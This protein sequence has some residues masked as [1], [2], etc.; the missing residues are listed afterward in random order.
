M[1]PQKTIEHTL[2]V[3]STLVGSDPWEDLIASF[4]RTVKVGE[5]EPVFLT[6]PNTGGVG[7]YDL[8]LESLPEHLRREHDCRACRSFVERYGTL[9]SRNPSDGRLLSLFWG[10]SH[11]PSVPDLYR[12][13]VERMKEAVETGK[14]CDL[15]WELK[16]SLGTPGKG[17]FTHF[18]LSMEKK[19]VPGMDVEVR[20][21]RVLLEAFLKSTPDPKSTAE[22]DL[23]NLGVLRHTEF[24]RKDIVR[25]GIE[26]LHGMLTEYLAAKDEAYLDAYLWW[27]AARHPKLCHLRSNLLGDLLVSLRGV[28]TASGREKAIASFVSKAD[29]LQ[30]LRPS[31]DPA[32]QTIERAE[33]K[34]ADLGLYSSFERRYAGVEDVKE[35]VWKAPNVAKTSMEE[36]EKPAKLFA[37]PVKTNGA[38]TATKDR[39]MVKLETMTVAKF[40]KQV[41]PHLTSVHVLC[42]KERCLSSF[43]TAVNPSAEPLLL[44]DDPG[45]RN[46]VSWFFQKGTSAA[47]LGL[48]VGDLV[49]NGKE[50]V[51]SG[52]NECSGIAFFP[53][54]WGGR[55]T[56]FSQKVLFILKGAQLPRGNSESAIFPRHVRPD[57]FEVRSVVEKYSRTHPLAG[58]TSQLAAGVALTEDNL[59][60]P[61]ILRVKVGPVTRYIRL[62]DFS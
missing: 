60:E 15:F 11:L 40:S 4:R 12:A 6:T 61:L 31:A 32:A 34:V 17:S 1:A 62:S 59:E 27:F 2:L 51:S 18:H 56:P 44:W 42:T 28:T 26:H 33:K 19:C 36:G 39:V 24:S 22:M 25:E 46:P 45:D 58:P 23:E 49:R 5:T 13:G 16:T 41:V 50:D 9:V 57:L 35:W 21:S 38:T 14:I 52:W 29:P 43:T 10:K 54:G 55:K 3:R 37:P 30:Y 7:L 48:C 20:T 53:D 47:D 8:F